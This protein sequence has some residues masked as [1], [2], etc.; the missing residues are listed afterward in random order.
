MD[1]IRDKI[2]SIL[3][4][5]KIKWDIAGSY[6]RQEESSGDIDVLVE[7]RPDFNMDGLIQILQPIIPAILAKGS[8]KTMG[9]IQISASYNGHRIDIRLIDPKSYAAAL[10]YFTGSQYFNILMRRRA[11]ELGLKL[12]EY[13]L[14]DHNG[15]SLPISSE[16]DIFRILKIAYIPPIERTKNIPNLTYI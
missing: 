10:M 3:D 7:S 4:I 1:L 13:G 8:T 6:R 5:Y 2:G 14:Y 9:V 11:I 16:E 12:N 15:Q